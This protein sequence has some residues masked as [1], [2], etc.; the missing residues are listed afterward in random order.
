MIQNEFRKV[1]QNFNLITDF[2][3]VKNYKSAN[4]NKKKI[5]VIYFLNLT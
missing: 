1:G 4:Q 2:G 3:H 5:L